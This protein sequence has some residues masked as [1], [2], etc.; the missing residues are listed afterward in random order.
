[1]NGIVGGGVDCWVGM[2]WSVKLMMLY[3]AFYGEE[4]E[5]VCFMFGSMVMEVHGGKE[6]EEMNSKNGK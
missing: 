5:E 2:V 6:E 1:M 3:Y 4:M